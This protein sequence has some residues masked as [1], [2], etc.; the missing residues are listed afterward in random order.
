MDKIT[1]EVTR[2]FYDGMTARQA[3][4]VVEVPKSFGLEVI[5]MNKARIVGDMPPVTPLASSPAAMDAI[6]ADRK[7]KRA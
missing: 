6:A 5:N 4:E 3:G 1:I 2:P 7:A